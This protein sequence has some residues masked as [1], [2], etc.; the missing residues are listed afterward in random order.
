MSRTSDV[1]STPKWHKIQVFRWDADY[2]LLTNKVLLPVLPALGP[3][4]HTASYFETDW[5]RGPHLTLAL[6]ADA[7]SS[8]DIERI[9]VCTKQHVSTLPRSLGVDPLEYRSVHE[10]LKVYEG[11]SGDV[12]PWIPDGTVRMTQHDDRVQRIGSAAANVVDDFQ[13][14]AF[15]MELRLL[16][17]MDRVRGGVDSY[18]M[19]LMT[20]CAAKFSNSGILAAS[21]SFMSHARGY[22]GMEG[23]EGLTIVWENSFRRLREDLIR[24]VQRCEDSARGTTVDTDSG[25]EI[26]GVLSELFEDQHSYKAFLPAVG[27]VERLRTRSEFHRQ[28]AKNDRW[29]REVEQDEWFA[30]YRMILNLLYIHLTKM[31]LTPHRRFYICYLIARTVEEM[32]GVDSLT[33]LE[34][35]RTWKDR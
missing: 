35:E 4:S 24:F 8:E 7:Y 22:L 6:N 2:V 19:R 26:L 9:L 27:W 16:S 31:G 21:P 28:L 34:G 14:R 33:L 30:G 5:F 29:V 3:G 12:F 15:D 13:C 20:T 10:R 25:I 18:A 32:S 17:S 23:N 11:R 1:R